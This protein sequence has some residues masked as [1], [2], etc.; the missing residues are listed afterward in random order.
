MAAT[1]AFMAIWP[2]CCASHLSIIK[3]VASNCNSDIE[4]IIVCI[5]EG[6]WIYF[7]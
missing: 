6:M 3:G 7:Y 5:W 4:V 2:L 1:S